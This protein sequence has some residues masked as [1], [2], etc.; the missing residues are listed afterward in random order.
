LRLTQVLTNL[1]N[2]AIKFTASG[3]DIVISIKLEEDRGGRVLL[4]FVVQDSGIGMAPEQQENLF[5]AFTQADS[6]TTRKFGGSGL[7]L[8]ISK[9]LVEMMGGRVWVES[10]A[11]EGSKFH[12]TTLLRIREKQPEPPHFDAPDLNALRVMIV[13]DNSTSREILGHLLKSFKFQV[14]HVNCGTQAIEMLENPDQSV[15]FD[16]LLMDWKMPE[17]DGIETAR[18]IQCDTNIEHTPTIIMISAYSRMDLEK[19]AKGVALAGLITKPITPSSLHNAVLTAMGHEAMVV[20][21]K[22][23]DP[24]ETAEAIS[25][26][27]GAE[28]LLVEDNELN[29]ELAV[30]LLVNRGIQV[31]CAFNGE[32]ALRKLANKRYSGI[33]MDCQM[34]VMDGYEATR[35][36]RKNKLV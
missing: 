35:L 3:G 11:S 5:K 28:I 13:D 31:E 15:P 4:H 34:P 23:C 20:R 33:L 17:M 29:Q 24:E 14:S 21:K 16:L 32:D 1:T 18:R 22:Q 25:R 6:S 2:N 7:G 26:L 19:A 12:F 10:K 27:S 30:D 8:V 36:I 9:Q